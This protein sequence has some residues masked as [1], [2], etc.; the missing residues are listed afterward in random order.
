MTAPAELRGDGGGRDGI[1]QGELFEPPPFSP[2]YPNP[3]SL[4]GRA[5]SMLLAGMEIE[6]PDFE[7]ATGSWRLGAYIEMLRDKN[8]PVETLPIYRPIPERPDR[9]VAGYKMPRWVLREV[10][11]AHG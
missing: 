2:T 5:L 4:E 6:H 1:G 8:W 9:I 10:G 7:R 3:S 11:A